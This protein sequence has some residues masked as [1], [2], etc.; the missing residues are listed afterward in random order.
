MI[1]R[2][3][4]GATHLLKLRRTAARKTLVNRIGGGADSR[5]NMEMAVDVFEYETVVV[6]ALIQNSLILI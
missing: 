5:G 4:A 3:S 1:G 6:G 2:I